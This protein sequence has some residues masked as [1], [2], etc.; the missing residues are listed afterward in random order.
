[1]HLAGLLR[2]TVSDLLS[3]K[4]CGPSADTRAS[5]PRVEAKGEVR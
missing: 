1:M 2:S 4:S 3:V 5:V